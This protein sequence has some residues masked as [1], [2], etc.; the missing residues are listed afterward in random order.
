MHVEAFFEFAVT[1]RV[2]WGE[3]LDSLPTHVDAV[4]DRLHRHGEVKSP[5][6]AADAATDRVTVRFTASGQ[7]RTE[8][9]EVAR[10]VLGDVIRDA[11]AYHDGLFPYNTEYR[12]VPRLH[13]WSGLRTPTWQVRRSRFSIKPVG[14][15]AAS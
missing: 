10:T 11:A 1:R 12:M 8:A 5:Y 3:G 6:C 7:T 4:E 14:E 9:E 2:P 13:S 15:V